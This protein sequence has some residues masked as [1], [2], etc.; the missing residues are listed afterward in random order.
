VRGAA[1]QC[2]LDPVPVQVE[3][4]MIVISA[5]EARP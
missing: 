1:E 5:S 2:W 4:G 3:N